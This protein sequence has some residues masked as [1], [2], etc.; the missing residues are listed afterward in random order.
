MIG[1]DAMNEIEIAAGLSQTP[2]YRY[3]TRVGDELFVAGQ[4]PLGG[5]G[6]IVGPDDPAGQARQCLDNLRVVLDAHS[7]EVSDIRQVKVYVV[8]DG[9]ALSTAWQAVRAWFDDDVPPA[10]LLGVA[11]LGYDGQLVEVDVTVIAE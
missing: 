5:D 4:V 1:P 8:G 3:A 11:R 9:G 2:G 7:F 10:T 6:S